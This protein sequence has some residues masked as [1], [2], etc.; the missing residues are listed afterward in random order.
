MSSIFSFSSPDAERLQF[1][2]VREGAL[3]ACHPGVS[4]I[5][6]CDAR[7]NRAARERRERAEGGTH[8]C[9]FGFGARSF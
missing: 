6:Q 2:F 7:L 4:G 1:L 3:C 5:E 8:L 9:C